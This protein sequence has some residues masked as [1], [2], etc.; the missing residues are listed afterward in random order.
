MTKMLSKYEDDDEDVEALFNKQHP[1]SNILNEADVRNRISSANKLKPTSAMRLGTSSMYQRQ[2]TALFTASSTQP[3]T[4]FR[5]T[6]G[7]DIINRPM[8]AVRGAGYTSQKPLFDPLNQGAIIASPTELQKDDSPEEKIRVQ[9]SKIM[10]LI[11][12]SCLASNEGNYQKALLKAKEASNK[13]RN[14]IRIQEQASLSDHH[15][16]DLTYSVLFTLANQYANNDQYS[17]ALS[18]YQMITKNRMFS[19]A[20]RLKVN[21]GN[22]YYKQAQH[23]KAIKMYRMALDQVPSS[24]KNLRYSTEFFYRP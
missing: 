12:E 3:G 23:H 8:T 11:E 9:E 5:P 20:Y 22:I 2:G 10:Q 13:E 21:M 17:E 4:G 24:Q 6:T 15:N 14:L 19:N 1:L 18:T 16:M 7:M